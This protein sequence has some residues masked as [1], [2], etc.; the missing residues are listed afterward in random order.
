[1][2][3]RQKQGLSERVINLLLAGNRPN[4]QSAYRSA[5]NSWVGWCMRQRQ[6]PWA[7]SLA[8]ILEY[9]CSLKKAGRSFN[10]INVYKSL[11]S[12]TLAP[13]DGFAIDPHPLVEKLINGCYNVN[14]PQPRYT[15]IR[16]PDLI[17]RFIA[18]QK[19]NEPRTLAYL[20]RKTVIL[21]ALAPLLRF[22]E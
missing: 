7:S 5:W 6:D 14:P 8:P 10:T 15:Y 13:I 3:A 12:S 1:M 20:S 4:T 18:A 2:W 17:L 22:S 21:V 9:L 16:D 11:L 19:D